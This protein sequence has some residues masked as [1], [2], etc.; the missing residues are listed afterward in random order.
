VE[1]RFAALFHAPAALADERLRLP[2]IGDLG[3]P[4]VMSL[5][6]YRHVYEYAAGRLD[7]DAFVPLLRHIYADGTPRDSLAAVAYGPD[8]LEAPPGGE[9]R[10]GRAYP[11]RTSLVLPA[12]GIAVLRAEGMCG[13]RREPFQVWFRASAH[14]QGHDH[15]DKLSIGLHA[16][17]EVIAPDLGTAGYGLREHTRYCRSTFAHNT[18]LVDE[19]DQA[20]ATRA[21][22]RA[23]ARAMETWAAGAGMAAARPER[24]RPNG[25]R[26]A[27]LLRHGQEGVWAIGIVEDAYP[28]VR[29]ERRV[30]LRPPYLLLEDWCE[31]DQKHRYGWVLHIYGSMAVREQVPYHSSA[32]RSW[33]GGP[34]AFPP[35]PD[36]TALRGQARPERDRQGA[37]GFP[38][39]PDDGPWAWFTNRRSGIA[40]G[41]MC[42]DWRVRDGLWVRLWVAAD[43]PFEWTAG[44][45]AGNPIPDR[46]G[47]LFLRAVGTRRRF[48]AALEVHRGAAALDAWPEALF[49]GLPF[50]G[51]QASGD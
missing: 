17:G 12:S 3:A 30:A 31:S 36:D 10:G 2:C 40:T 44:Q 37:G 35:R 22:L 33:L 7:P 24:D 46:R 28:G 38:P 8:G 19:A 1:R 5:R 50:E 32:S 21:G 39:L 14:G 51:R 34:G 42:A 23:A 20:R 4:K 45:T 15:V 13:V 9:A 27:G 29:L 26:Q 41:A 6:L 11:R 25:G 47:T 43:G 48:R 49:T 16:A 18:L